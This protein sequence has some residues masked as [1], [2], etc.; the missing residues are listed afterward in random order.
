MTVQ[1]K[2]RSIINLQLQSIHAD[3]NDALREMRQ[4]SEGQSNTI[5][6]E[7]CNE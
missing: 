7:S 5:S 6:I 2:I 1:E 3:I 4:S